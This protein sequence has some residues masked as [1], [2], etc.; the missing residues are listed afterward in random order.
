MVAIA[1]RG[2]RSAFAGAG[3]ASAA[4]VDLVFVDGGGDEGEVSV[5]R[6]TRKRRANVVF[7]VS[8]V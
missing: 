5:G 1:E 7:H 8:H 4:V 2:R 3:S 6:R